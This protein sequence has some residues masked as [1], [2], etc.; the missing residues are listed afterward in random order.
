M[1]PH[2]RFPCYNPHTPQ[3]NSVRPHTTVTVYNEEYV[4]GSAKPNFRVMFHPTNALLILLDFGGRKK[5]ILE[6][7][8]TLDRDVIHRTIQLFVSALT[9]GGVGSAGARSSEA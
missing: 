4:K 7:E 2:L 8:N 3:G 5:I 6:C 9:G 1:S